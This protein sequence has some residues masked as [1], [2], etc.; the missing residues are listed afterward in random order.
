MDV[1]L[2]EGIIMYLGMQGHSCRTLPSHAHADHQHSYGRSATT[3]EFI[4]FSHIEVQKSPTAL[5]R[6]P[7]FPNELASGRAWLTDVVFQAKAKA[8]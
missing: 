2:T 5:L 8:Q 1:C 7:A 3:G 4:Q 6:S